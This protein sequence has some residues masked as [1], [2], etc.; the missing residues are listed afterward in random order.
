MDNNDKKKTRPD[1]RNKRTSN[2][3]FYKRK[4]FCRFCA[5]GIEVIDY[6]NIDNLIKYTNYNG[7]ILPKKISGNC[8]S[9]QRRVSNAIKRA[10][11]VALLPFIAE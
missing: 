5:Q 1:F 4:K 10:R 11:I 6:K 8:T 7:K 3:K 2:F 9:H